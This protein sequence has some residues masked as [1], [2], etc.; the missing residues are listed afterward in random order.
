MA[1]NFGT[2]FASYN[3][4]CRLM[5]YN[6]GYMTAS[7]TQF[8]EDILAQ[9]KRLFASLTIYTLIIILM[10]LYYDFQLH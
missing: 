1:T 8:V 5:G 6:F 7:D 4:L 2:Q 3:W 9:A 10:K